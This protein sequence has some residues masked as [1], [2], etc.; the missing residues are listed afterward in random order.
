MFDLS[1]SFNFNFNISKLFELNKNKHE[2]QYQNFLKSIQNLENDNII[3]LLCLKL[4]NG[5]FDLL[6][7]I[8]TNNNVI[9]MIGDFNTDIIQK[10]KMVRIPIVKNGKVRY[11]LILAI[12]DK[13][14][15]KLR[16]DF[17]ELLAS[18]L[19]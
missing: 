3:D 10:F 6:I 17:I 5:K 16:Y 8:K 19:D 12:A 14:K 18:Y 15:Y 11:T 7:L 1:P 13:T 2:L 4:L 9:K